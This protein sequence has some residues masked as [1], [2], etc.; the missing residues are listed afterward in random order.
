MTALA[1]PR[2]PVVVSVSDVGDVLDGLELDGDE[3]GTLAEIGFQFSE[4]ADQMNGPSF[5][6]VAVLGW[7]R[8]RRTTHPGISWEDFQSSVTISMT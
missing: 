6:M 1:P 2:L 7:L 4:P 5:L 8:V 3:I